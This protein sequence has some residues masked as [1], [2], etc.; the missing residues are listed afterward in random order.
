MKCGQQAAGFCSGSPSFACERRGRG[1]RVLCFSVRRGEISAPWCV[2]LCLG[3]PLRRPGPP[4]DAPKELVA[5]R[6][7]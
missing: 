3:W 7:F 2:N 1:M 5:G 4:G 6:F